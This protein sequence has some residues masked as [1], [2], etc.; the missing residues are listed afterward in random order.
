MPDRARILPAGAL[1]LQESM[2]RLGTP[3]W[4]GRGGIRQGALL[5]MAG[6]SLR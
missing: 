5:D 1:V 3:L 2:R 6:A 4:V